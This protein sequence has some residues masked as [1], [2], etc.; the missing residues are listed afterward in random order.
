MNK[1]QEEKG[2]TLESIKQIL[3]KNGVPFTSLLKELKKIS[4]IH[5]GKLHDLKSFAKKHNVDRQ[6]VKNWVDNKF[7]DNKYIYMLSGKKYID[8][9]CPRPDKKRG[10]NI[11]YDRNDYISISK[12]AEN[13]LMQHKDI[14]DSIRVGLI[15]KKNIFT[16][17]GRKYIHKDCPKPDFKEL[18]NRLEWLQKPSP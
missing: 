1:E 9:D 12:F 10:R 14:C 3:L 16:L 2:N 17:K 18:V 13:K 7:I 8:D 5:V 6:S 11:I 15:D 4:V